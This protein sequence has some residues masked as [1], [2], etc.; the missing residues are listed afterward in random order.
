MLLWKA[1]C[2]SKLLANVDLVLFLNKCDILEK[3][4]NSGIKYVLS[5]SLSLLLASLRLFV[6][7]LSPLFSGFLGI[8]PRSN[9]IIHCLGDETR[10]HFHISRFTS[11]EPLQ[12]ASQLDSFTLVQ[13][14]FNGGHAL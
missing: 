9:F 4:L 2:S 6:H 3:K 10:Q 11:S 14:Q 5:L 12:L 8:L 13:F 1:V 7:M